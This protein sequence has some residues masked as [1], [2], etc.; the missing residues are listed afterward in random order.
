MKRK[1]VTI[2]LIL[3]ILF[4]TS[5]LSYSGGGPKTYNFGP[6]VPSAH[7]WGDSDH[8]TYAPSLSRAGSGGGY[9]NL[10]VGS[11]FTSFAVQFYIKYVVKKTMQG[12]NSIRKQVKGE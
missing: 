9:P 5:G 6:V 12:Q 11:T 8:N 2:V 3:V 7:P 1:T 10:E 4:I